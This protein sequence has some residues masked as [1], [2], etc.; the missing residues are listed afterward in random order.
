MEN[1]A[2]RLINI[3]A[4]KK[5]VVIFL[6][7]DGVLTTFSTVGNRP[8]DGPPNGQ[9]NME[10]HHTAQL[11][12]FAVARLNQFIK[13]IEAER[14]GAAI[15]ISSTWRKFHT[16]EELKHML[17]SVGLTKSESI[18]GVTKE[19]NTIRGLEIDEWL[20]DNTDKNIGAVLI[21]DDDS[22]MTKEQKLLFFVKTS[23]R[24]VKDIPELEGFN[25]EAERKAF[26][27]VMDQFK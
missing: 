18:I 16:L 24:G 17:K 9:F 2:N 5:L 14:L 20:M 12:K 27:K 26:R 21:L 11:N 22:D 8:K 13:R 6:D 25:A 7:I 23:M 3:M 15:V 10:K 1:K 19:L 4:N